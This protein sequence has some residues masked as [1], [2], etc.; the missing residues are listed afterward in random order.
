MQWFIIINVRIQKDKNGFD[1]IKLAKLG[2]VKF[3][4][5]KKYRNILRQASDKNDSTAKIKHATIKK[6]NRKY[7]AVF[8]IECVNVP[9]RII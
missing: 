4:T 9:E 7:Y 5:S 6:E 2:L 3:K 1:K 8:N